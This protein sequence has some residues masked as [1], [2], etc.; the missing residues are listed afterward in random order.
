M[1]YAVCQ[2]YGIETGE[3]SF[4]YIATWSKDRTLP[5]LRESLETINR[6]ADGLINDIDQHFAEICKE[7]GID[8][9]AQE[10]EAPALDTAVEAVAEQETS[11]VQGMDAEEIAEVLPDSEGMFAVS[12]EE[13]DA[14][15]DSIIGSQ[16][17][18]YAIYQLKESADNRNYSFRPL[19]E[20][21]S[22]GLSIDRDRYELKYTDVMMEQ[23]STIDRLNSLYQQFNINRPEDFTGHSL[24]VSDIIVLRQPNATTYHY[25][26][27]WGFQALSPNFTPLDNPLKNAEMSVEDDYGMID[28]IINNGQ[29][30]AAETENASKR[31]SVMEQLQ[32]APKQQEQKRTARDSAEMER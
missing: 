25:V 26:D 24:S 18:T 6:T 3:N 20:L 29:K 28:G 11:A 8:L 30:P 31:K 22:A 2:Y 7:R 15:R 16:P 4:G 23:G 19:S 9:S 5:E 27:S 21:H 13:W 17:C 1:S 14:C 12:R 32:Q 10:Q